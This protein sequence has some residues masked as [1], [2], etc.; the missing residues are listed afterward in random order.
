MHEMVEI[1]CRQNPPFQKTSHIRINANSGGPSTLPNMLDTRSEYQRITERRIEKMVDEINRV[2]IA[3]QPGG[4]P[5]K[6]VLDHVSWLATHLNGEIRIVS[7]LYDTV[8]AAGLV[9]EDRNSFAAQAG[10]I[11]TQEG[12]LDEI[13]KSIATPECSIDSAVRW[14]IPYRDVIREEARKWAADLIVVGSP[15]ARIR[16]N[17]GIAGFGIRLAS[18]SP[19][20]VLIAK[21]SSFTG[22]RSVIAA[23]DPLHRHN[24][25]TGT[26]DRVLNAATQIAGI[27]DSSLSVLHVYPNPESFELASSVEVRPGVYYGAEN[28]EA[29]HR[30]AVTEVADRYDIDSERIH[31]VAGDPVEEIVDQTRKLRADLIVLSTI[32]RGFIE[33]TVYGSTAT[34]VAAESECDVLL[35]GPAN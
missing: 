1:F 2:L 33:E 18:Q 20:P 6:S 15:Q 21:I 35:V 24:E 10:M 4:P 17:L 9:N 27:Q 31:L 25:L 8:I 28:I 26:D 29:A 13:V 11:N 30:S 16:A 22:Y 12:T 5:S 3:I 14:G 23:I 7:C 34:R 19:C 32:K